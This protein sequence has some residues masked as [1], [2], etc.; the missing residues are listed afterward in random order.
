MALQIGRC[1][2]RLRRKERGITQAD[3]SARTGI[4]ENMI[5]HYENNRRTMSL[6]NAKKIA[7]ALNCQIEDLYVWVIPS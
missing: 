1:L 5:G 3:L 2:L 4:S 6:L 7:D